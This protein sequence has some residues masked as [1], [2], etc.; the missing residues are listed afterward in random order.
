MPPPTPPALTL[1]S[2][3]LLDAL[4][5]GAG[6]A[7]LSAALALSRVRGT[8]A[9]F[10]S[11][12][13]RNAKAPHAHY[14]LSR[15]HQPAGEIRRIGR[16]EVE[17]Y[18]TTTFVEKAVVSARKREEGGF[19]VEDASG[20]VWKGRAVVLATGVEDEMETEIEGYEACWG[21][22]IHQCLFCDG[23]EM[24]DMPA[25]I[26]GFGFP[27][28]DV[29][30][31]GLILQMGCPGVTIFGN[32]E[33]NLSD[34]EAKQTLEVAKALGAEVDERE[35]ERLVDLGERK[36]LEICFRDGS[37]SRV[38]YLAHKPITRPNARQVAEALGVEIL[39]DGMGGEMLKRSEPFGE[40]NVGGVFV[41]GD[42]GNFIKS[43]VHSMGQGVSAGIGVASRLV[44]ERQ[45][46][47]ASE[48]AR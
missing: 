29:H 17:A 27:K 33:L 37:R 25:G 20:E 38:G 32:G 8:S 36:G 14:T 28:L 22:S 15:D 40:S 10:S 45:Q 23:I 3:H 16:S 34:A 18:G 7:G 24:N 43:F 21:R 39:P 5:L 13:F 19:E 46:R 31:V 1:S 4:I 11:D 2:N 12:T 30:N 44:G 6:P 9:V 42:A 41:A 48:V 26:L 47:A 35:I